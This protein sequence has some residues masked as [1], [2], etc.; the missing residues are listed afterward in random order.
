MFVFGYLVCPLGFG[1]EK[2]VKSQVK[3]VLTMERPA[4]VLGQPVRAMIRITNESNK[5]VKVLEPTQEAVEL[6]ITRE[7]GSTADYVGLWIDMHPSVVSLAPGKSVEESIDIFEFYDIRA[8]GEY[9]VRAICK[10]QRQEWDVE[11][12]ALVLRERDFRSNV[13]LFRIEQPNGKFRESLSVKTKLSD[14]S[15]GLT[16]NWR[17]F[18]HNMDDVIHVYCQR[19]GEVRRRK[20]VV[21]EVHLAFADL[22]EPRYEET[23][24]CLVDTAGKL[25][26]LFQPVKEAED[27]YAHTV[28]SRL[29]ELESMHLY[30][31]A[32]GCKPSLATRVYVEYAQ[33]IQ[34]GDKSKQSL[35]LAA[36]PS[37][38][39][40]PPGK[41]TPP[42]F[43][44]WPSFLIGAAVGIVIAGFVLLLKKKASSRGKSRAT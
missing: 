25:H 11:S 1:K 20:K 13:A 9:K 4:F 18:T 31:P 36:P 29:G 43:W 8:P 42:A 3:C 14:G 30:R 35:A 37:R 15:G 26:V 44:T 12:N 40:E 33:R 22:G 17:V 23:V 38:R 5:T 39:E 6:S 7:D 2:E 24:S 32:K 19:F 34:L 10:L 41:Q 27:I 28:L 16:I 21:G